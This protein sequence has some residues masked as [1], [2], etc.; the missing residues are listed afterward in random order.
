[1]GKP[2]RID[3]HHHM[4]P[5]FLLKA[6]NEVGVSES[7]GIKIAKW[8]LEDSI[9]MMDRLEVETAIFALTEPGITPFVGPHPEKAKELARKINEYMAELHERYPQRFGGFA[10]L[11]LPNLEDAIEEAIYA[12]D[13]LKLDGIGLLSNYGP[14]FL[15]DD[16]F[17]PLFA[18]LNKRK[19]VAYIHPSTPGPH[20]WRPHYIP[21]DSP[22]EFMFCTT[23]AA[24]NLIFSGTMEKFQDVDFILSHAA[25]TLPYLKFRLDEFWVKYK[26]GQSFKEEKIT[27]SWQS[28]T[29]P[30]SGYM[31]KFWYDNCTATSKIVFEAVKD[32]CGY[33]RMMY[34]SDYCF[35]SPLIRDN[36]DAVLNSYGFTEEEKYLMDRGYAEQLFPRFK[37]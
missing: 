2:F 12:L 14:E 23:R 19:A 31:A 9:K 13:V 20:S 16:K 15:G 36:M 4:F 28:L 11:P 26:P 34:G 17:E 5:D 10:I 33:Y 8:S 27:E 1:M 6:L 22:L 7:G 21:I 37:K 32:I 3:I 30:P 18:E 24:A 35:A 25:G 29:M